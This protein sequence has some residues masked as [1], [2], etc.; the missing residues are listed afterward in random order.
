M[1]TRRAIPCPTADDLDL[2]PQLVVVILA[3]AA[4]VAVDRALDCAHPILT[5]RCFDRRPPPLIA[6]ER[7]AA[8]VLDV[9]AELAALLRDYADSVRVEI[10]DIDDHL[11]DPF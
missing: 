6:S 2:A 5:A 4:L 10:E 9:C 7:L 8:Q 3:D 11:P 1:S